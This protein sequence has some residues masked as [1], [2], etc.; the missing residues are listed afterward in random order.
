MEG[1]PKDCGV[2]EFGV[3]VE[4]SREGIV[5]SG[6]RTFV[7]YRV[8][9]RLLDVPIGSFEPKKLSLGKIN[10]LAWDGIDVTRI[11]SKKSSREKDVIDCER[12]SF[13]NPGSFPNPLRL[14]WP[15]KYEI[16]KHAGPVCWAPVAQKKFDLTWVEMCEYVLPCFMPE[17]DSG[18]NGEKVRVA[19]ADCLM[20]ASVLG[21]FGTHKNI[22]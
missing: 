12:P 9:I 22:S 2:G 20:L 19:E 8:P 1:M 7:V 17:G 4:I 13:V 21:R 14:P 18:I 11:D 15:S 6:K 10:S 5:V 3:I 16:K